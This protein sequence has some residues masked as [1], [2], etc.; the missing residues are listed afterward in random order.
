MPDLELKIEQL[1]ATARREALSNFNSKTAITVL[2]DGKLQV[3]L[4]FLTGYKAIS[5]VQNHNLV[6]ILIYCL[7]TT[8]YRVTKLVYYIY[9][10]FFRTF[11]RMRKQCVPGH[12]FVDWEWG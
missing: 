12:S 3:L 1:I 8:H 9:W 6:P 5:V 7:R 10:P 4:L 2:V 11:L